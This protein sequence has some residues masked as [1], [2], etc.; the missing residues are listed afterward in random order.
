M[1]EWRC[2]IEAPRPLSSH[3]PH[4]L[5]A[6]RD[7]FV[8]SNG[9]A[10]ALLYS[11]LHLT[12]YD[13]P[14][15]ELKKFRKVDSV[16]AGHPENILHPAIEVSTGPLGQGICNGVGMAMAE[17]HLASEFNVEG[18]APV[19]DSYTYVLCG[20][21]C[22]Q[23]G[24]SSE[25]SSL[26]GH[27]GLGKLIVCYDDNKVTIDGSTELSFTEDVLARYAAYGWHTLSVE[28]GDTDLDGIEAA[29]RAAQ[30][31]KDKPTMIK[32]TTTIGI[33]SEKQGT[34]EVHG[35][36]LGAK[37]LANVK[38]ALGFDPASSFVVPADVG[39][40]Y[41][42][43]GA[44]A[45]AS[46]AAWSANFD[47][48]KAAHPA[49]ASEFTRR[50][51]G[52]LPEGWMDLLP[53]TKAGEKAPATRNQS[54]AVLNALAL[55][56]PELMGG[57]ADLTPSNMTALKGIPDFQKATPGGRYIRF[58]VRE[59]GMAAICNGMAAYGAILPYCA[60]FMN[61]I[62][63]AAGA[64]RL[65]ALSHLRVLYVA[66][67]DSIGL[68]EDGPTHQPVEM[69]ESLRATPNMYVYRPADQNE[70]S[71][72]YALALLNP[73]APAVFALAR[74][75]SPYMPGTSFEKA[76]KGGYIV[77][78]STDAMG[79][80]AGAPGA[81]DA[82]VLATGTELSMAIEGAKIAAASGLRVAVASMPCLEVFEAQDLDYRRS[83]LPDG[84]PTVSI[85]ASA[86]R[87]WERY[88]HASVGLTTFGKSGPAGD[89]YK[90]LSITPEA[91]A[92]KLGKVVAHYGKA[93]PVLRVNGPAF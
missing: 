43:A 6:S 86:I 24:L 15:D 59:H 21:G 22:L 60:T 26:A 42:A 62:G 92:A 17:A 34:G 4:P 88:A 56:M 25:A 31:V 7:R 1:G 64:V 30:A 2:E 19:I 11:M 37:D 75:A 28:K 84:V 39:E 13:L 50:F 72:S 29:I 77:F 12:G 69:L 87:G 51:E 80:S 83:V 41:L 66:T 49:K 10:C 68:G 44:K 54:G 57:S 38:T 8:L 53:R 61:F 35:A 27:L 32:I 16:C 45:A 89:V 74:A 58:G 47:A 91:L 48:Y 82:L 90:A 85:E 76:M 73:H 5:Q 78:D 79:G 67:H 18:S 33:G 3:F 55:A 71:A 93:A 9:H 23:E 20:D 70:T 36:P 40:Y 81:P 14:L 65:S 46:A 52:R 63:Y